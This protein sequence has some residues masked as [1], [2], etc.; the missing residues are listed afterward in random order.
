MRMRK[1][2]KFVAIMLATVVLAGAV[3]G[4]ATASDAKNGK[5]KCKTFRWTAEAISMK[6]VDTN[7]VTTAGVKIGQFPAGVIAIHG[8]VL[9]NHKITVTATNGISANTAG[10]VSVGSVVATG[11]AITSTEEDIIPETAQAAMT[12]GTSAYLAAP[13]PI[14][15]TSTAAGVYINLLIDAD[16]ATSIHTNAMTS[17]GELQIIYS[18]LLDY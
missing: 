12:N 6:I 5:F 13:A 15:G 14:D 17:S 8:A 18:E 2:A 11:A 1:Y 10:D 16:S 9:K 3:Y 4:A 7:V